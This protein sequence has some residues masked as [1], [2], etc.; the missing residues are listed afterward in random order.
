M[1]NYMNDILFVENII[2][3]MIY[4]QQSFTRI[5]THSLNAHILQFNCCARVGLLLSLNNSVTTHPS[6]FPVSIPMVINILD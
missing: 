4:F 5:R 3:H 6:P 1:D 2:L